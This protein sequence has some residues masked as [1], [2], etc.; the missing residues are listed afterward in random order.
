MAEPQQNRELPVSFS[1]FVVSLATSAMI[2]LGEGPKVAGGEV[3]VDLARQTIDVLG[4]LR[5]KTQGN[6]DEEE[7]KLLET[8]LYETRTRYLEKLKARDAGLKG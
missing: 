1:S 7:S 8:L 5:E 6:L 3:N 4:L 2:H